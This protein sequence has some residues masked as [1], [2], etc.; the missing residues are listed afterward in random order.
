MTLARADSPAVPAFPGGEWTFNA[1]AGYVAA[2]GEDEADIGAVEIGANYFVADNFSLGAEVAG[3]GV[4]QPG[5][6]A[7]A[8]GLSGVL[9]HHL[10]AWERTTL[11][12]D[13]SFGPVYASD[14]VP[15]GGTSFNFISR[16][17]A[18]LTYEVDAS[19]HLMGGVRWWHLSNARIEG[20]DRNPTINGVEFYLGL[21]WSR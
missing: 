17:G 11:F 4:S 3:Y 21:M 2:Y 12:L 14:H 6:D 19:V 20:D 9:R 13:A 1:A 18:G 15:A 8:V 7:Y 5:D 16:L 10:F